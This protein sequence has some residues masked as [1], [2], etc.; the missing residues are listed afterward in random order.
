MVPVNCGRCHYCIAR[1]T[2]EWIFRIK[3]ELKRTYP[4][5]FV[6][7][8]YSP[9]DVPYTE[10]G[11]MTLVKSD[12]QKYIKRLRK[13]TGKKCKYYAVGEYGG[14]YFRP[15]YHIILLGIKDERA[16]IDAWSLK[17]RNGEKVF[18]IGNV[19]IGEV[20]NKTIAY[21]L[22]YVQKGKRVGQSEKDDRQVEFALI[23]QNMGMN[24]IT[25]E[26]K[27]WHIENYDKMYV[28]DDKGNK[29][30]IP[31]AYR[32][33]IFGRLISSRQRQYIEMV[34]KE[35]EIELYEKYWKKYGTNRG[36]EI[37]K[38]K[39]DIKKDR[40]MFGTRI[41]KNIFDIIIN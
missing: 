15:H 30:P 40:K 28:R 5:Y 29:Y 20:N 33:H 9:L 36:L 24:Y 38:I 4:G 23:S 19:N 7:L 34:M 35:K 3:Q 14:K 39:R 26:I 41:N 27:N 6:T 25:K 12:L 11:Y 13:A 16:I 2:N 8:T 10:N 17:D 1:R 37:F 22:K 21:T 18:E 31:R 32:K